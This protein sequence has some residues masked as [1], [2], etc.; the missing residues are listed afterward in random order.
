MASF[1]PNSTFLGK[2][3]AQ[4]SD[5]IRTLHLQS[6][7]E[8][9]SADQRELAENGKIDCLGSTHMGTSRR[10]A[11]ACQSCLT[12]WTFRFF[13]TFSMKMAF[14]SGLMHYL[15]CLSKPHSLQNPFANE[16]QSSF[17]GR[18]LEIISLIISSLNSKADLATSLHFNPSSNFFGILLVGSMVCLARRE[19]Y[20][21][22]LKYHQLQ[23]LSS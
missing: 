22:Y 1:E 13:K 3:P 18:S 23:L 5:R 8:R 17:V 19:H 6:D 7:S 15:W 9:F 21:R 10:L 20:Y 16:S 4:T 12:F 2:S 14:S 11:S